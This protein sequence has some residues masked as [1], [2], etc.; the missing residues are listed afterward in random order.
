[1]RENHDFVFEN[2][3]VDVALRYRSAASIDTIIAFHLAFRDRSWPDVH[4]WGPLCIVDR[5]LGVGELSPRER[6]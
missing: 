6:T 1:M 4:F 5:A 3:E 2:V